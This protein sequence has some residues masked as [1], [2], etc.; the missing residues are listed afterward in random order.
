MKKID[1]RIL[2]LVL[3]LLFS[4]ITGT[5]AAQSPTPQPVKTT[6]GDQVV[7]AN[8]YR[9]YSGETLD[10]NLVVI[11][12][13]AFIEKDSNITKGVFILGGTISVDGTIKG[14]VIAIGG[15]VNLE[16]TAVVD[17]DITIVGAA[18]NRSPLATV[19]GQITEQSPATFN[20]N[21]PPNISLTPKT[22]ETTLS[23]VLRISLES[24]LLAALAVI[25]ALLLPDPIKR[26]AS[27]FVEQPA[28]AGGVGLLVIVGYPLVLLIMI[29]TIL[30][31]PVAILAVLALAVTLLYGWIAIGFELGRQISNLFHSTWAAAVEAGI[32]TFVLSLL[33]FAASLI[34]CVGWIVTF[35]VMLI[36]IGSVVMARFGSS[37]YRPIPRTVAPPANTPAEPPSA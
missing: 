14:D 18:F 1:F 8:T 20:Y 33:A 26:I 9:L 6:S 3:M 25:A 36:A 17:G 4:T 2:A 30:L 7:I 34:P 12:S 5:A 27:A 15:V 23:K 32:G 35:L 22:P 31:I 10:G 24:F 21:A 11:G 13:T 28:I 29:V 37:K 19:K 16:D